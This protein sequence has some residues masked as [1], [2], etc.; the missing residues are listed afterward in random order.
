[1]EASARRMLDGWMQD[2]WASAG[3]LP[4]AAI[5]TDFR[6]DFL[7]YLFIKFFFVCA[8]KRNWFCVLNFFYFCFKKM[9]I[10]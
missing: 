4:L 10:F 2:V 7:I 6:L 8:L 3:I 5:S 1:M 9:E